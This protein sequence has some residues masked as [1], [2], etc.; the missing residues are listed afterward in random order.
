MTK[1]QEL[2]EH[3]DQNFADDCGKLLRMQGTSEFVFDCRT[4]AS[5]VEVITRDFTDDL[6]YSLP[7]TSGTVASWQLE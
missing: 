5:L 7:H 6:D 2:L 3:I 4:K 1:K